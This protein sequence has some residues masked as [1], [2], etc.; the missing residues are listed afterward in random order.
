[1]YI[2]LENIVIIFGLPVVGLVGSS[3]NQS[4]FN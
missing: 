1:V 2:A 3:E 4:I